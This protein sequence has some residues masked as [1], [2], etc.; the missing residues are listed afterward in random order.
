MIKKILI[1]QPPN[2]EKIKQAFVLKKGVVFCYGESLYNPDNLMVSPMLF[3]HECVHSEQQAEIGVDKW[4]KGYLS[5]TAFRLSQEILAYQVQY[6][7]ARKGIKDRN[8]LAK[9]L[10][11]LAK[12]LSGELY[13]G[14]IGFNEALE[15]IRKEKPYNFRT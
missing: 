14:I 5:E 1:E 2:I 6:Q 15:A 13:G 11:F 4:W 12:E 9:Y 10:M 8:K 3:S 7:T